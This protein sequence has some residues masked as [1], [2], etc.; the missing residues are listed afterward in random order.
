MQMRSADALLARWRTL[1]LAAI[2]GAMAGCGGGTST[3]TTTICN[4][5]SICVAE[6]AQ[7]AMPPLTDPNVTEIVVDGGPPGAFVLGVT[8]VPYVTV[9]VCSPGSAACVT[10]DHVLV[11]T[12]SYGLRLLK[13]KV[14]ALGLPAI[15]VAANAA[16]NT[17]A[18]NAAECYP[19]VL[20]AVWGPLA[21][22]DVGVASE[23]APAQTIQLIDDSS[24]PTPTPQDCIDAAQGG[25]LSSASQLQANGILGIGMVD[26]DCGITC[27]TNAQIGM[28]FVY[29]SCPAGGAACMPA[30]IP[31]ASQVQNPVAGFV[32]ASN[33]VKNNNGTLITMP[34]LPKLGAK[35]AK[36]RLVFGIGTQANNQMPLTS[37]MYPVETDSTKPN[38][39]YVGVQ[40]DGQSYPYSYIDTGS[41]AMFFDNA[42][43]Q[44][45]TC[46]A[47]QGGW[48][49]PADT[50]RR[51]ATMTGSNSAQGTFTQG[52]FNLTI[53][54][55]DAL[56]TV[57]AVAFANLG[58]TA[59]QGI[60]TF[61]LGMPFFYGKQVFTSIW[62]K[63]LS[64]NG[65][66][67]AF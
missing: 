12:G 31:M 27:E 34:T 45:R 43:L 52:T 33:G 63:P 23:R 36:G 51:T 58:G 26:V 39:L 64:I 22:A 42:T 53:D 50:W 40:V 47:A 55:A 66:W 67:Y 15:A 37:K 49:C 6:L 29:Y 24:P 10:I 11:D 60:D 56:F 8:N 17:P 28:H 13:S 25:L 19:F 5:P 44:S 7:Q 18:G 54:S 38:Y 9:T 35:V 46:G 16:N 41:N 62:G 61:A 4:D 48:Y 1:L 65:P 14:A 2:V 59:G 57:D 21:K 3:T 30:A 20:G 32:A